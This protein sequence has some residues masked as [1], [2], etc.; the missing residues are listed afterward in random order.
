MLVLGRKKGER[1]FARW[2]QGGPLLEITVVDVNHR[3]RVRLG[4][5]QVT[6]DDVEIE[7]FREEVKHLWEKQK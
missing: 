4:F 7:V 1:I 6:D 3:G 2:G 5:T